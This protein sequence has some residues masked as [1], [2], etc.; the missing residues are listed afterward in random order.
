M[1]LSMQAVSL[2]GLEANY[3]LMMRTGRPSNRPR[4]PFGQRIHAAREIRGLSQ[5]QVAEKLGISQAGYGS[6]ERDP[7]ALHPEQIEQ[8]AE[9]LGVSVDYL[10]GRESK[11][12]RGKGP[13]GKARRIFEMVSQ[14]PRHQQQ[15]IVSVVEAFVAQHVNGHAKAA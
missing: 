1:V 4:T 5:Q 12:Q 3:G 10:F 7:V 8:L 11:N 9:I 15:Q 6:W 13:V 14:L 2:S